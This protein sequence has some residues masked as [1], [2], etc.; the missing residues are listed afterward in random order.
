MQFT[1]VAILVISLMQLCNLLL[2]YLFIALYIVELLSFFQRIIN[3]PGGPIL[4]DE[5]CLYVPR[6]YVR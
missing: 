5:K 4:I 2:I 3:H 6:D 1:F